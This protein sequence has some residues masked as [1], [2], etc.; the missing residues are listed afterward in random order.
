MKAKTTAHVLRAI[1]DNKS[2]YLFHM[3]SS[4]QGG[5]EGDNLKKQAKLTRKQYY[6]RLSRLKESGIVTKKGGR[7]TLTTFGIIA[8]NAQKKVD[9]A[10]ANFW[11]I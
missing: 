8:Y 10:L 9:E 1:S 4:S 7:Y 3:I 2:M 5:I 6:T 11:K